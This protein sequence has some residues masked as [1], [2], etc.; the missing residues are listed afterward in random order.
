MG[1]IIYTTNSGSSWINRSLGFGYTFS[2]VKMVND[3]FAVIAGF[4]YISFPPEGIV[5]ISSD[6]G[7]TWV[8]RSNGI[9]EVLN[10]VNFVNENDGIVT[11]ID[12]KVFRTTNG[13][14]NWFIEGTGTG[15]SLYD[16]AFADANNVFIVG[17][18]GSILNS[19]E[20]IPVELFSFTAYP[21]SGNIILIWVTAT[22]INNFG[23]EIQ[24]S[25]LDK[26]FFT[27]GFVEGNGTTSE[28]HNYSYIDQN[29][30]SGKYSYR[31]KQFDYN[32]SYEY[33]DII[34][35][36]IAPS[37]FSLSQNY[38]NPFNPTTAIKFSITASEFVTLKVFDVLGNEVSTLVNEYKP[39]AEYVVKFNGSGLPSGI[40]FYR[41]QAGDPSTSSGQSF[42]QTKKM[43]LM[44]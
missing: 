14:L 25:T 44:K 8:N 33:S 31:L 10:A 34:K 24:R 7:D 18:G 17:E 12:G 30:N 43:I 13:G 1:T 40:Y 2:S 42:I 20:I 35:V 4:D 29:L 6:G 41:L 28:K 9:N 26:D 39:A 37:A 3:S 11:S 36:E 5:Y 23:F 16:V 21:A 38:P 19:S 15:N 22:E 27:I 32:G